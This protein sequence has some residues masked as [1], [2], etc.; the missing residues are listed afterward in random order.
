MTSPLYI[1]SYLVVTPFSDIPRCGLDFQYN[2]LE[3]LPLATPFWDM[4]TL[5]LIYLKT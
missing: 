3:T 4:P 2:W 1:D 5:L